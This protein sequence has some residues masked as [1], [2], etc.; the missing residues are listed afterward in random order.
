MRASTTIAPASQNTTGQAT[1]RLARRG[2]TTLATS[3]ADSAA[4]S[5]MKTLRAAEAMAGVL[6]CTSHRDRIGESAGT[7]ST[8]ASAHVHVK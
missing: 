4:A 8:A 6:R 2:C 5:P 1:V 7:A 3:G